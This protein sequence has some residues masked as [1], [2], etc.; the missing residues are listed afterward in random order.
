ALEE[1]TIGLDAHVLLDR[2]DERRALGLA[3]RVLPAPR[4]QTVA[5]LIGL[6]RLVRDDAVGLRAVLL[7]QSLPAV[8]ANPSIGLRADAGLNLGGGLL[9][10]PAILV[11]HLLGLR[12]SGLRRGLGEHAL[13][14]Q[15]D[16]RR[17]RLRE[18]VRRGVELDLRAE[19]R[20]LS[21]PAVDLRTDVRLPETHQRAV[22]V[23]NLDEILPV[24]IAEVQRRLRLTRDL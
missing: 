22:A 16:G 8:L 3:A 1:H 20:L 7:G 9:P 11:D 12:G 21:E 5:Q 2:A 19:H 10:E 14:A 18:A 15:L 23:T 13:R 17:M 6:V 4:H 24:S